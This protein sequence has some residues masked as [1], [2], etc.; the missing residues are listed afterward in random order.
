MKRRSNPFINYCGTDCFAYA[1]NDGIQVL[2]IFSHLLNIYKYMNNRSNIDVWLLLILF[3]LVGFGAIMIYSTSAIYAEERYKDSFFF[4]K[5]HLTWICIG[6]AGMFVTWRTDYHILRKYSKILFFVSIALLGLVYIPGIGRS[7]GGARRW[8]TVKGFNIQP[9]EIAKLGLIVYLADILT[10]KQRWLK[11]FWKGLV[12]PLIAIGIM[13]GLILLQPDLGTAAEMAL[14]AFIILFI[15]GVKFQYLIT[16]ALSAM[17]FL[18]VFIFSA[19]Y[20][21]N[22][23]LSFINPWKDPEGIGFQIVQ[24]FLALG[25]GGIFGVGL[26]QSRQ[27]LFY[28]PAAHTDFIFSI[29]GEELGIFGTI[30]VLFLFLLIIWYGARIC[31]KALD[32]FGHFLALGIVSLISVQTI[33]N[34]GVVTG[35]FPTKGLPLPFIS[36]GGSCLAVYLTSFGIL[37]NIHSWTQKKILSGSVMARDVVI[38]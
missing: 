1:R 3:L 36:Y 27:K 35:S 2:P 37:L 29:V 21:R 34:I 23:I 4:L 25:S 15:A 24:S 20:R 5:K 32:L 17:P 11:E 33:I 28:L 10:R 7:A 8:L 26:G 6:L 18:Y 19:P 30:F 12:T 13:V 22:R 16:L 31:L 14:V 38:G 9:S